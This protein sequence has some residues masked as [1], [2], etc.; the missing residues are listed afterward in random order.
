MLYGPCQLRARLLTDL[1]SS[2]S[3]S[4]LCPPPGLLEA[5][6]HLLLE[7]YTTAAGKQQ[8]LCL[9][10]PYL[11]CNEEAS[12]Q[13]S[14]YQTGTHSTTSHTCPQQRTPSRS[15]LLCSQ[16][17]WQKGGW[18]THSPSPI[19][20]L[21][22][23][24]CH[25]LLVGAA[26]GEGNW[27]SWEQLQPLNPDGIRPREADGAE[28]QLT[29]LQHESGNVFYSGSSPMTYCCEIQGCGLWVCLKAD[30]ASGPLGHGSE[31]ASCR[32]KLCTDCNSKLPSPAASLP[33]SQSAYRLGRRLAF[34]ATSGWRFHG[35]LHIML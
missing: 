23:A 30:T 6:P 7:K 19:R 9:L 17:P 22:H 29:P 33:G 20:C 1:F 35:A 8:R 10:L 12:S 16:I 24:R 28:A 32:N 5:L 26:A 18:K 34:M 31:K 21:R 13:H 15:L 3:T 11:K 27:E 25:A 2:A 4:L 14:C